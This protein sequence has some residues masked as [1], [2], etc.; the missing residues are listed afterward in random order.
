MDGPH[1]IRL[2]ML[3]RQG[4]GK[5]TQCVRLSH[6]FAIPHISTGDM[7]RAA[8]R[9]NTPFGQKASE[10]MERGELVS[11]EVIT[12]VV[13]ERLGENDTRVRGFILDGFPR[14]VAQAGALQEILAPGG[15]LAVVDLDVPLEVV[16]ARLFSRR[17]CAVCGANYSVEVFPKVEGICDVCGGEIVQ[18]PD[19]T[20]EAISR[21]LE[22]YEEMTRPLTEYYRRLGLLEVVDGIGSLDEV[23]E[24]ILAALRGRG[25]EGQVFGGQD[26]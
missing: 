13:S 6:H 18:R 25:I 4:A 20:E 2:A 8:V 23:M 16:K 15:L 19:D 7:L 14:T 17:V 26:S 21:R 10:F 11:D 12:G 1:P 3:G 24:R 22:L 5:G 9:A